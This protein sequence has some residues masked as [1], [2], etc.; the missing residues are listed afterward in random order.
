[1][2]SLHRTHDFINGSTVDRPPFHPI[3]MRLA[4][5]Y[6]AVKYKDFC[7]NYKKKCEANIRC[8]T[9]FSYDWVNVMSDPYAEASAYGTKLF[10]PE[11]NLPQVTEYLIKEISDIDHLSVIRVNDHDRLKARVEEIREFHRLVGRTQFICG[12]VE[13]PL[14]AYCDIRDLSAACMDMYEH[15][16]KVKLVLNI[17]AESAAGFITAQVKAGAHCIGIGDAVCS[18]ISPELYQEFVFPLEKALIEHTHSLNAMVKLHICGNTSA[19]LP[20][21]INTGADIVDIDHLVGSMSNF[22]NLFPEKQVPS[23]NSD[24]VTVIRD[25]NKESIKES[26]L[27]CFKATNGRGIVSAGCEIPPDTEF[28][29]MTAYRDAAHGLKKYFI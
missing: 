17:M 26:V 7:L 15:P 20:D 14:A 13:G 11:D 9:D 2:N 25:G 19:I 28:G 10:Y 23:G 1:M 8:S 16:E 4:A 27:Q 18:L 5:K 29:N 3:L 24:P 22:I 12:W 6:A 21:M